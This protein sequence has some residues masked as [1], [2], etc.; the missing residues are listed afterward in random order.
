MTELLLALLPDYGTP[1][2]AMITL[3]SCLALPVPAS[4]VMMTAGGF[5]AAGDLDLT[6]TALAALLGAVLGDQLGFWLGRGS[7]A[8]ISRIETRGGRQAQALA[9]A[10]ALTRQ[11]GGIAV[12]LTRWLLSPLGPYVNLAAGAARMTW[13]R[14]SLASLA[15]ESLWV[16]LYLG[17]GAGATP[18]LTQLWPMISDALGLLAALAVAG[19]A[20]I[21]LRHLLHIAKPGHRNPFARK[22]AGTPPPAP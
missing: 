17:L 22:K 6:L 21:R 3:L 11:R 19:L 7:S 15:G 5:A 10:T 12:F 9:R 13:R 4:L 16:A 20:A 8:R 1:F 14:F 18:Y 2:V